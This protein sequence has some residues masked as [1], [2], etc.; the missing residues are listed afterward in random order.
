MN[1]H[2]METACATIHGWLCISQVTGYQQHFDCGSTSVINL[3]LVQFIVRRDEE[4][5]VLN[6]ESRRVAKQLE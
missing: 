1:L 6:L 2:T 5:D 4:L 3:G